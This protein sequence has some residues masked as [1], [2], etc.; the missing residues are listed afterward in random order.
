MGR[1]ILGVLV[2]LVAGFAVIV[3]L[4]AA[5]QGM[6]PLPPGLNPMDRDAIV[7]AIRAM[8]AGFLW[9]TAFSWLGGTLAGTYLALR[10]SRDP[11]VSWPALTVEA[12]LLAIGALNV[13]AL[14]Y[15]TWFWLVG[16]SSF[17]LGAFAG[18]RLARNRM[19]GNGEVAGE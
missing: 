9:W 13:A 19:E 12:A 2:G 6:W 16:L 4:H 1:K 7:A 15:P 14:S 8:P 11:W 17:P 5:A 18:M 3:M 10:I